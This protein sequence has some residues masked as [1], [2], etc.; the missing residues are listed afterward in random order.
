MEGGDY[1]RRD[2]CVRTEGA[3]R[4]RE[5]HTLHSCTKELKKKE[6]EKDA[7]VAPHDGT[8]EAMWRQDGLLR[9]RIMAR[10]HRGA[11]S[12]VVRREPES[13]ARV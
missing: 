8:L 9:N 6:E 11:D 7:F 1:P 12:T 4:G 13:R 3:M 10:G 2:G 5:L